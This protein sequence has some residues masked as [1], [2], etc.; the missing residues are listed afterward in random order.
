MFS[1]PFRC[2][3]YLQLSKPQNYKYNN[4]YTFKVKKKIIIDDI[5]EHN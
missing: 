1:I 5:K 3:N 4:Y 2:P